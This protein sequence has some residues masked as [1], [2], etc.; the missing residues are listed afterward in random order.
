MLTG[1]A[2]VV[3]LVS[4][5][6]LNAGYLIEHSAVSKLPRLTFSKPVQ[7]L[8]LLLRRRW[9]TGFAIEAG[10]WLLYVL[11]LVLAPLSL[12]QATA[13]GGIGIL[14][15]MVSRYTGEALTP[16][17]QLGSLLSV[18]GLALLAVSLAGAHGKGSEG[19]YLA[20]GLWLAAS[21]GVAGFALRVAPRLIGAG[22]SFGFAAGVLFAAGDVTTKTA[23]NG[24]RHVAFVAAL[25]ACYALGT[26]VLQAGFQRAKPLVTA[27]L[28]T[29]MTN[30]VPI[31]AGMTIFHEPLP[32]GML[33]ALRVAAFALVVAGAVALARRQRGGVPETHSGQQPRPLEAG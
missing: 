15:V 17:E 27:G 16:V 25:I 11:A 4:A 29:L 19:S 6:A 30:A 31:A 26:L 3:T 13:A 2:L 14:A 21:L 10:G 22:P 20:V 23:V 7:S 28:A 8:R 5:C 9:L 32:S 12:V 1:I 33:G 18:A 24:G